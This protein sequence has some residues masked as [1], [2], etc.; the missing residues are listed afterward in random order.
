MPTKL[1][2]VRSWIWVIVIL[3]MIPAA[4]VALEKGSSKV[5]P[6]VA[7]LPIPKNEPIFLVVKGTFPN[8]PAAEKL[9]KFIQQLMVKYP[10]DGVDSTD[11]YQ[12]LKPGQFVVGTLFDSRDR[13][14]WW[15]DFS[16]RNRKISKGTLKEV[17]L[18][19]DSRLPYMPSPSRGGQKRLLTEQEALEK[20]QALPD[21][22]KLGK[23]KKL[24]YKITDYP[25]N[26]DLRYEVEI[27]E[28]R[29]KRDGLMV[30]FVMVSAMDGKITERFSE[31]LGRKHFANE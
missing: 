25:K 26:G 30:D 9:Q 19:G 23:L 11:R 31:S 1:K 10:G 22:A 6:W 24:K 16:Y 15:M 14:H 12:G 20:A 4:S 27:L 7:D 13:A 28:D 29:G 17:K 21:L 8:R 2:I 18:I 5:P 3:G